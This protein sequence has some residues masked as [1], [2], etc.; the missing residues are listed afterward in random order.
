MWVSYAED[1]EIWVTRTTSMSLAENQ[2]IAR[3]RDRLSTARNANGLF[4]VLSLKVGLVSSSL[5]AFFRLQLDCG[6]QI[7]FPPRLQ[8][9]CRPCS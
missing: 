8:K 1:I 6:Y 3:L 7:I 9:S 2:S 5:T 4:G